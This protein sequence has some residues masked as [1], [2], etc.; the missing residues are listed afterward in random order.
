MIPER[1]T[2]GE[3]HDRWLA[4]LQEKG[5]EKN[6]LDGY[7]AMWKHLK[8]ELE[9]VPIHEITAARVEALGPKMIAN[10]VGVTSAC[11]AI[12]LTKGLAV[13]FP[14]DRDRRPAHCAAGIEPSGRVSSS[15]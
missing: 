8:R 2:L 5:R 14:A 12:A 7:A 13:A 11:K 6:T 9:H 10:G 15:A 4:H 3:L 1:V